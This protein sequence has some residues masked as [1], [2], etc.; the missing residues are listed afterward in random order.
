MRC[1]EWE[2]REIKEEN[3]LASWRVR[4]ARVALVYK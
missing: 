1:I 4:K 3:V 2:M